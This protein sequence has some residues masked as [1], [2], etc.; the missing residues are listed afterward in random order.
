MHSFPLA[1]HIYT[2]AG[3]PKFK[4]NR[5]TGNRTPSSVD[6]WAEDFPPGLCKVADGVRAVADE[7]EAVRGGDD[8]GFQGGET[9]QRR[10]GVLPAGQVPGERALLTFD[11]HLPESACDMGFRDGL[12]VAVVMEEVG[13]RQKGVRLLEDQAGTPGVRHAARLEKPK[14]G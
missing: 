4:W 9:V 3:N 12:D 2:R 6:G 1:L 8:V 10:L 7:S 13:A 11:E 5:R 14:R